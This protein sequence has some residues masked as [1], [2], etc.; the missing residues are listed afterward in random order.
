MARQCNL[1]SSRG[2]CLDGGPRYVNRA[3]L[4]ALDLPS[5]PAG[6]AESIRALKTQTIA[7]TTKADS[8]YLKG[9]GMIQADSGAVTELAD[10]GA[11]DM[12][13]R[14]S[15]AVLTMFLKMVEIWGVS[16]EDAR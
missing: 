10:F 6:T 4:R 7:I 8:E 5:F 11:P 12:Q 9:G 2:C 1:D 15:P 14:L 3:A 13:K 16:D